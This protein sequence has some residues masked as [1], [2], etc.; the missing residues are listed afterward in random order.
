MSE[1]AHSATL[2]A[3]REK[4]LPTVD[5]LYKCATQLMQAADRI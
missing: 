3:T 2:L 5:Q 4:I 1:Y